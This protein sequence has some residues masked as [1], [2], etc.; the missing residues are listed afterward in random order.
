[1]QSVHVLIGKADRST[2]EQL[3]HRHHLSAHLCIPY[4]SNLFASTHD[5]HSHILKSQSIGALPSSMLAQDA[6][7]VF[8]PHKT[9]QQK[10]GHSA[11]GYKA[12]D[13]RKSLEKR[14]KNRGDTDSNMAG[15]I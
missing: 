2:A 15:C 6:H 12:G 10:P 9:S 4:D 1:M 14:G 11:T 3:Q 13:D 5:W 8:Q 7:T